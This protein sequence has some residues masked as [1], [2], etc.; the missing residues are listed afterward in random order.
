M[1]RILEAGVLHHAGDLLSQSGCILQMG[2]DLVEPVPVGQLVSERHIRC[3]RLSVPQP[4]HS[5]VFGIKVVYT[6]DEHDWMSAAD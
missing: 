3:S 5:D 6:A 1:F 2:V 4:C